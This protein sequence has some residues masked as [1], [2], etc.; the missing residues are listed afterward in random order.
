M[1]QTKSLKHKALQS[2]FFFF[3]LLDMLLK[4]ASSLLTNI[5]FTPV[6]PQRILGTQTTKITCAIMKGQMNHVLQRKQ[7]FW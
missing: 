3:T 5:I 7:V 4:F 2:I 6:L 1:L